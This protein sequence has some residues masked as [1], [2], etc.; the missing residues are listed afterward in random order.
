MTIEELNR[1]LAEAAASIPL[2][3][4]EQYHKQLE[5]LFED[6]DGD[7]V[8][9]LRYKKIQVGTTVIETPLIALYPL[10]P[11]KSKEYQIELDT[12]LDL[13]GH[14]DKKK[15]DTDDTGVTVHVALKKGLFKHS[16]ELKIKMKFEGRE[17]PEALERLRDE[18]NDKI[19]KALERLPDGGLK[20][21]QMEEGET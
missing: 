14:T 7:G 18:L 5:R 4:E 9:N 11:L 10:D 17:T 8:F 15:G 2:Y 13:S 20:V 21:Y 6:P 12:D 3:M 19:S 1:A 16:S